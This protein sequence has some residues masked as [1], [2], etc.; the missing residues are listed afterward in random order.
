[1]LGRI[2][3]GFGYTIIDAR[4]GVDALDVYERNKGTID[5]ILCD[6]GMPEMDG[7]EFFEKIK[8]AYPDV[9]L[10]IMTGYLE[11]G[12]D[13]ELLEK[14]VKALVSKPF[15]VSQIIQVIQ[16]VLA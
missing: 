12:K 6:M 4:N 10:I 2:L 13:E 14:G 15:V 9:K 8:A 5:L 7:E 1:V 11:P 16:Q 3:A